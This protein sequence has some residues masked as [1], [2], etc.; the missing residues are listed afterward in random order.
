MDC[1]RD[2]SKPI[3]CG[4]CNEECD[5][6]Y[7]DCVNLGHPHC[8]SSNPCIQSKILPENPCEC[9][10]M[11]KDFGEMCVEGQKSTGFCDGVDQCMTVVSYI[12]R[13][14][15]GDRRTGEKSE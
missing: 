11:G 8:W 7:S 2:T 10:F 4:A 1:V 12:F 13:Y 5:E 15:F 3:P 6:M 14:V 9:A